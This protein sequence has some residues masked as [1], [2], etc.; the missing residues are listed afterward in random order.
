M[1][2]ITVGIG[3]TKLVLFLNGLKD[4]GCQMPA[5]G[6]VWSPA[7]EYKKALPAAS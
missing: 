1:Y 7:G 4:V 3:I 2:W 6:Q 5:A